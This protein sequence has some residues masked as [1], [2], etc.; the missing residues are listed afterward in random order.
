MISEAGTA[1]EIWLFLVKLWSELFELERKLTAEIA[2]D[3]EKRPELLCAQSVF[4]G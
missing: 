1:T 2:E 3:A 4:G